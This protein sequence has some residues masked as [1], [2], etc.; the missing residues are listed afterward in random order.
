MVF[1]TIQRLG[2]SWLQQICLGA[3]HWPCSIEPLNL[4]LVKI[5]QSIARMPSLA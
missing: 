3:E 5:L 1:T 4:R 2:F